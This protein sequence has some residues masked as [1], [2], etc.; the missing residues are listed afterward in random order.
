MHALQ[1]TQDAARR[2]HETVLAIQAKYPNAPSPVF[3]GFSQGAVISF[4]VAAGYPKIARLVV[5]ISGY[6]DIAK[7]PK[8]SVHGASP[9]VL[10]V[11]GKNDAVV[12]FAR[13]RQVETRLRDAGYSVDF[14]SHTGGH[15]TP[16]DTLAELQHWIASR[17]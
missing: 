8:T 16:P 6:L 4:R 13:G 3:F 12:P 9:D 5:G 11:H 2:V 7:P 15:R 10:I 14:I 1:D 17:L